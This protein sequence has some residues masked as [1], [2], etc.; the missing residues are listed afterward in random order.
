[1]RT[2]LCTALALWPAAAL[3]QDAQEP[4]A[5]GVA[6]IVDREGTE[7]G[8]V[9]LSTMASGFVNVVVNVEGI[10]PGVHGVHLHE[11]G[12]CSAADFESA[13]PHI[14]GDKNHGFDSEGGPH[15]GDLA[16][17]HVQDDGVLAAQYMT[18]L[19][20]MDDSMIFDE[21]GSALIIHANS[22][23]YQTDPGGNAG[24][25]IACGE[26]ARAIDE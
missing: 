14:S 5:V 26:I 16:N 20:A 21:D 19:I 24:D 12:D 7:I 2:L 23:D 4:A 25:R 15:P 18:D 6:P 1:M 9:S 3:A 10:P 17:A 11:T 8:E 13:G 22:D